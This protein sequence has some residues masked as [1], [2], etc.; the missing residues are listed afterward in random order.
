MGRS[1]PG[2]AGGELGAGQREGPMAAW[3]RWCVLG[4]AWIVPPE[5]LWLIARPKRP[6]QKRLSYFSYHPHTGT[7]SSKDLDPLSTCVPGSFHVVWKW[8]KSVVGTEKSSGGSRGRETLCRAAVTR[9]ML[10]SALPCLVLVSADLQLAGWVEESVLAW[11]FK[12]K[13]KQGLLSNLRAGCLYRP[14]MPTLSLD[15]SCLPDTIPDQEPH[16]W[17]SPWVPGT[18]PSCH[19]GSQASDQGRTLRKMSGSAFPT[20]WGGAKAQILQTPWLSTANLPYTA[21]WRQH[22]KMG[23]HCQ[24]LFLVPYRD[25]GMSERRMSWAFTTYNNWGWQGPQVQP[26]AQSRASLGVTLDH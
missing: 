16:S 26:L 8:G 23:G 2:R 18:A 3:E 1:E 21:G 17:S 6:A 14:L 9:Q 19:A 15:L 12:T 7:R 10:S 25:P 22:Q 4:T 24:H 13:A 20:L 11:C 5:L